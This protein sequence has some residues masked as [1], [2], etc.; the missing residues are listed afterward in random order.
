MRITA[1]ET[2]HY[3][4][5]LDPPF[6]AAWDPVPRTEQDATVVAV[7][8]DEGVTGYASG[9]RLPDRELLERLLVGRRPAPH[10]GRARDLRDGR[11]PRRPA[12]D[13]R[14]G[15]LGP[16]RPGA[17]HS[18]SGSC[19]AAARSASSPTRRAASSL[20]PDER[21]RPLRRPARRGACA[22]VKLRFHHADWR[23]DVAVVERV[24]EA[25]GDRAR[26]HG[27][28]EPGLAHARRP[29]ARAG[30]WR[31]PRS[32]RARSR[33]SASTGSRSRC[34][35]T[36]STATRRCARSRRCARRRRDG[37]QRAA[38]RATSCSAAGVDVLQSRRAL[39]RRL[40]RLPPARGA[41]RPARTR[42]VAAHVVERATAWSQPP[43]SRS[44]SRPCRTSRCRS[45]RRPGRPSGATGCCP[46][47]SRSPPTGRSRRR[48]GPG[49]ASTPD[50]DALERWRVGYEDPRPSVLREPG[51]AGRR[52]RR[53][54]SPRRRR[55]RCSCASRPPVSATPTSTSPTA[56]SARGA[57]RWCSA[58][59]ARASSRRSA[60]ASRTS[61]PATPSASAFVPAC[62]ACRACLAGRPT[63]CEP[64]GV[65][66]RRRDADGRHLAGSAS[67]TGRPL[68]H[69][70]MTACFAERDGRRG[71]RRRAAAAGLPLWQAALLGCGVVTGFGAVRNVARVQP[72]ES[73]CVIGVRRRRPAGD[74]R[75]AARG[76]RRRSSRSTAIPAKLELALR[77]GATH[78]VDAVRGRPAARSRS[79]TG[80]GVD[81]AFEVVGRA[82][83]MRLAWDVLRARRHR[84]RRR[85][86]PEGRRGRAPRD[87]V[88]L[89]QG[90]PRLVLRLGRSR[91]RAARAR[92]A[93]RRRRAPPRRGR[94]AT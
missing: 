9:D 35:P 42:V 4:F 65:N 51:P 88:P 10:R 43:R 29:R 83:T 64:A 36:T 72:G 57:G 12:L 82:E 21:A 19:S 70:L 94:D 5:P 61:R 16:G 25:V 13:G 28:R 71:G 93:R 81:H 33:G 26:D 38:R 18:R 63:L 37:A 90:H 60:R 30:T 40:R 56:R 41:G 44:R 3:R 66:G 31:R 15:G 67:R 87:R 58:T 52:S 2:R 11:L 75:R 55:A 69:G 49:S 8:T 76:R 23:D 59:R 85:P 48:P 77:R 32:A 62:G 14:G 20:E 74:R 86:R 78:A 89:R 68:Q 80:G 22:A 24:R 46:S 91:R 92:A 17:R 1:V 79:L 47:R 50:L 39:R 34:A 27:R 54:S 7:H 84:G 6:R 45:T 73:V 53:W